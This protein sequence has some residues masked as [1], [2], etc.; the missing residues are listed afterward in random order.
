MVQKNASGTMLLQKLIR[1]E[2]VERMWMIVVH[3]FRSLQE[4]FE[5]RASEWALT[6]VMISLSLVF[7][8]ND[9]MFY[10]SSFDGMRGILDNRYG[11]ALI[12]A[13]VGLTRLAVLIINGS[14]WRTP[15][16]RS[17]TAFLSAGVWFL[18]CAGFI[19]NGSIMIAIAPWIFFLDAY[20]AKR[21]S[22]EAGRSE[23]MQR[24][25]TQRRDTLNH[26]MVRGP[27]R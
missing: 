14:H 6:G 10:R 13:V 4:T 18:F 9:E 3:S 24:Y 11:W 21:A 15:H 12:L 7:L 20:N 17:L 26:G 23:Y 16:M 1:A 27:R 19:H 8:L 22:H 2:G 25:H 5:A